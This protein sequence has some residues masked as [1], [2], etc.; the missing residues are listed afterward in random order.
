[1]TFAPAVAIRENCRLF[2]FAARSTWKPVSF[3][4]LSFHFSITIRPDPLEAIRVV[5]RK[6][7]TA[8]LVKPPATRKSAAPMLNENNN[9]SMFR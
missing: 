5:H 6:N 8:S 4:A 2:A 3:E 1:V 9:W 7:M